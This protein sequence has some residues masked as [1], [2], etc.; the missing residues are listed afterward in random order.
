M[1]A[2]TPTCGQLNNEAIEIH[3]THTPHYEE[4]HGLGATHHSD[5]D[6]KKS[7]LSSQDGLD[8]QLP[9]TGYY[10]SEKKAVAA[11]EDYEPEDPSSGK[12]F[13]L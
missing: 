6:E 9:V 2:S 10:D 3:E 5:D 1:A 11:E 12:Q 8:A 13:D 7:P 4:R